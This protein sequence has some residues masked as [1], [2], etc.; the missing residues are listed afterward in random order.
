M[1]P[2]FLPIHY[3]FLSEILLAFITLMQKIQIPPGQHVFTQLSLK[4]LNPILH[5]DFYLQKF[6]QK[7]SP[8]NFP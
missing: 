8:V 7:Q 6:P 4:F 1:L 3:P 5:L 2:A